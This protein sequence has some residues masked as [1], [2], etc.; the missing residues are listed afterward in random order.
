MAGDEATAQDAQLLL[1]WLREDPE[2]EGLDFHAAEGSGMGPGEDLLVS[3]VTGA[4]QAGVFRLLRAAYNYVRNLRGRNLSV[5]VD[6]SDT[7]SIELT[8]TTEC[9]RAELERRAEEAA[10]HLRGEPE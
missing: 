10:R 5:T 7:L 6:V 3:L 1:L 2:L 8:S 9:T 4:I